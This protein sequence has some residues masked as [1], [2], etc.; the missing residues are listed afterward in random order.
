MGGVRTDEREGG[1]PHTK[2]VGLS[3]SGIRPNNS[4]KRYEGH[5]VLPRLHVLAYVRVYLRIDADGLADVIEAVPFQQF[6]KAA[7]QHGDL[8]WT[9]IH[10]GADE[11]DQA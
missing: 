6:G 2:P 5:A 9:A 1:I 8:L 10:Q 4:D 7:F 3:E 11:H